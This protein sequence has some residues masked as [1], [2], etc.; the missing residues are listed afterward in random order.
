MWQMYIKKARQ[1]E[2]LQDHLPQCNTPPVIHPRS[3]QA[4]KQNVDQVLGLRKGLT[5]IS[6]QSPCGV[7]SIPE[8]IEDKI[9]NSVSDK[10]L[11]SDWLLRIMVLVMPGCHPG[12]LFHS[13]PVSVP[14]VYCSFFPFDADGA[15]TGNLIF[16]FGSL[17][18][19]TLQR[20]DGGGGQFLVGG[21][22]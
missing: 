20:G 2:Q 1:R 13:F 19:A 10:N 17:K 5:F 6:I 7:K 21:K 8:K 15:V 11:E 12:L 16:I 4:L 22:F 18:K 14:R 3:I 9:C